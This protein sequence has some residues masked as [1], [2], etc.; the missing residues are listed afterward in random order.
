M[1]F[2]SYSWVEIQYSRASREI[3]GLSFVAFYVRDSKG[4]ILGARGLK[5][6]DYTNLVVEAI[7]IRTG[8]SYCFE[9]QLS[10]V[11]IEIDSLALVHI[12]NGEW[13]VPWRVTMEVNSIN[14]LRNSLTQN[15]LRIE[16]T[17]VDFFAN[18][19]FSFAG[20]FEYNNF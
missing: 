11:I 7:S 18:L 1:V 6:S 3:S 10:K 2:T 9:K 19:V 20:N 15:S 4:Y 16:N 12:L 14:R 13:E 8:F 5:V 17:L